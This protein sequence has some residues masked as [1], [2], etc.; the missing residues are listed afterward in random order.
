MLD[1]VAAE[2]AIYCIGMS[3]CV[4]ERHIENFRAPLIIGH[5]ARYC[6]K[7]RNFDYANIYQMAKPSSTQIESERWRGILRIYWR[8]KSDNLP[9]SQ[10]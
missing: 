5:K 4:E 3:R 7:T 9:G 10:C 8:L 1:S 6:V 2:F